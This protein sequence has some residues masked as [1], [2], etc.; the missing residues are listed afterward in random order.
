MIKI[1]VKIL[2]MLF[3]VPIVKFERLN[4]QDKHRSKLIKKVVEANLEHMHRITDNEVCIKKII[5]LY[6]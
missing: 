6:F 5:G 1:I 2:D 3:P 4:K